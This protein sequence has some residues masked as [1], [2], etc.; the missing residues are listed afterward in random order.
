MAVNRLIYAGVLVLSA[1]FYFASGSWYA[2]LLLALI[3]ALP[4]LS[5]LVSLPAMLSCRLETSISD[6]TPGLFC[7][8]P[9][10]RSV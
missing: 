2:W 6:C 7:L 1:V 3:L 8:C 9:R 5:L 4:L 10:C